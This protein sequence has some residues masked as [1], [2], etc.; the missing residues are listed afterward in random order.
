NAV[1]R[2]AANH[3]EDRAGE[4]IDDPLERR[5][6]EVSHPRWMLERWMAL[7]G[8]RE[9][10]AFAAANNTS[11]PV[12]F[13]INTLKADEDETLRAMEEE[14]VVVEPSEFVPRAFVLR[15]GPA[16]AIARRAASGHL[17]IQDEAS[18][19]VSLLVEAKPGHR[20]L[21]LCAAPGS[22][23]SHL[24]ALTSNQAEIIAC[25]IHRHRL[26]TL[27]SSCGR[28]GAHCVDAVALDAG[29]ELPFTVKFDRVLVDA[30]CSGT[31]TLRRNPEIKWRLAP[32]DIHRLSHLQADLLRRAAP[33]VAPS[34]R[35][36]YSTCSM[37]REENEDVIR[38]FLESDS[39]FRLTKPQT[40]PS[41]VTDENFVRTFPHRHNS[42]GFFAAVME[43]IN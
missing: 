13:R 21:D 29:G 15:S 23:T 25:D 8:E 10:L 1:L 33:V 42:D 28:L 18:Q 20:I 7:L 11:P 34:G 36:V 16:S 35:L 22:K 3:P 39:A 5:S 37:E 38:R 40:H 24:A 19:L 26:S 6:V 4:G 14:G 2:N 41:L 31:G 17:Y 27:F 12:A 32:E 9:A 30:P 43:R